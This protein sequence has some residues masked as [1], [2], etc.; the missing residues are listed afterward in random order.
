MPKLKDHRYLDAKNKFLEYSFQALQD[1]FSK[2]DELISFFDTIGNDNQKNLFLKTA[3]F[4][5][6][7]VKNG[8]WLVD[9]SGSDR[10][11]DY[12]TD[13]YKYIAIFSL[14][15]SLQEKK[16]MDF[17]SFLVSC[18]TNVEFPINNKKELDQWYR[19]YKQEYGSIHQSVEFFESLSTQRKADLIKNL[20]VKNAEATIEN[21]SK[22]LYNLRSKFIHEAELIVN[23]SGRT[24]ISRY[25][26]KVVICKLSL[27]KL[28]LFFEE[29]LITYFTPQTK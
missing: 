29:G 2:K 27:R 6:F 7:L 25:G 9:I 11:V 18:K 13:T 20:K 26:K 12:F 15:E 8:D 24:T 3:S 10:R 19:K 16:F 17:Y 22:Y 23:M 28:M 5:L 4:Y 21:L 1:Q 14:I